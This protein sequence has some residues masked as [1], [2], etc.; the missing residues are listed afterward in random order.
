MM[1]LSSSWPSGRMFDES[2]STATSRTNFKAEFS[3]GKAEAVVT[4]A[5]VNR[6]SGIVEALGTDGAGAAALAA[7]LGGALV[8][9]SAGAN[10]I[11]SCCGCGLKANASGEIG[12]GVTAGT[13][14]VAGISE[15][16][17]TLSLLGAASIDA[18]A[19]SLISSAGA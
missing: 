15:N 19:A 5:S 17:S 3:G 2:D 6:S 10:P 14:I 4:G 11:R 1:K 12:A 7:K 9:G 18:G 16:A 8:S 13:S